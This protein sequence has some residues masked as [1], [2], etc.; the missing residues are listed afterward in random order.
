MEACLERRCS[1]QS[2]GELALRLAA[3][4]EGRIVWSARWFASGLAGLGGHKE[5][6][7][8]VVLRQRLVV[9]QGMLEL[10]LWHLAAAGASLSWG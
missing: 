8:E 1:G 7:Q 6:E 5:L 10:S 2:L 3:G 9:L 4:V